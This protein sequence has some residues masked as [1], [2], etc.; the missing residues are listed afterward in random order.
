MCHV[1]D[2][3]LLDY[4]SA[5]RVTCGGNGNGKCS[6]SA[7]GREPSTRSGHSRAEGGNVLRREASG[8]RAFGSAQWI[9]GPATFPDSACAGAGQELCADVPFH[10]SCQPCLR[11]GAVRVLCLR[12]L[13]VPSLRIDG[14]AC[15]TKGKRQSGN[16]VPGATKTN[17]EKALSRL[18]NLDDTR[19]Q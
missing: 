16:D 9:N 10:T 2:R 12:A 5:D 6:D 7:A 19:F 1:R 3:A 18:P 4:P 15:R 14:T 8:Q 17:S 13:P 11:L